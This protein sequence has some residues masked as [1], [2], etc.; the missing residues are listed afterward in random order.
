M[1][2]LLSLIVL[3]FVAAF[4]FEFP[5]VD[6]GWIRTGEYS[7]F[8]YTY[9]QGY[10]DGYVGAAPKTRSGDYIAGYDEGDFDA[11]CAWLKDQ[12]RRREFER[13]RCGDWRNF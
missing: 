9:D 4:F 5:P 8:R 6:D 1:R 12:N 2:G 11:E 13:I 7:P 10:D 3:Y